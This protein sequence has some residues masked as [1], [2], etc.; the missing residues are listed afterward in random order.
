MPNER[1]AATAVGVAQPCPTAGEGVEPWLNAD[2]RAAW[3]AVA[4]LI[5]K[6]PAELDA[7][8]QRDA[9]LSFFEYMVMAVLSEQPDRSLQ[10]S[11]IARLASASLSRLSH[12]AKRLERQG[13]LRRTR[14]GGPGRRTTATLTQAG[15]DKV[16]EAAPGHVATV[17]R[18]LVDAV[19]P[20][21][22]ET[23]RVVGGA[24]LA[25]IDPDAAGCHT[26]WSEPPPQE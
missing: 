11:E 2:E 13:Y 3:L 20:G 17:R 7:Q 6:L 23:L 1:E 25:R 8:L 22:L 12:T 24:V 5:V 21:E 26:R 16:A 18:V 9:G 10:M 4:A 19:D 15:F 14:C